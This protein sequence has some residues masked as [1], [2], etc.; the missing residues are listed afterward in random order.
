MS[1]SRLLEQLEDLFGFRYEYF[2]PLIGLLASLAFSDE[3][4]FVA[5]FW[6]NRSILFPRPMTRQPD[7]SGVRVKV[8]RA[9]E[10]ID[11]LEPLVQGFLQSK[12]Y[13]VFPYNEP[14]T[15]DLVYKAKV[16]AQPPLWWSAVIG[17]AIHNLRSSLDLLICELVR[18][19][20]K[21]VKPNTGFPVFKNAVAFTN[22][23]K[24]GP[25]GQIKG[26]PK[27]AVD[28]IK[29]AKPYKGGDEAF[30]RLH[31]LDITDKHKLLVPVGAA[32]RSVILDFARAFDNIPD[33]PPKFVLPRDFSMPIGLRPADRQFP[34]KDGVELFR[35]PAQVRNDPMAQ[36]HNNPQFTFEVAFGEGEVVKGEPLL[37]TLP[38]LAQFVEEFIELFPPLFNQK[39]IP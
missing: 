12:P 21:E 24:S 20:G 14:D 31:Q 34:L 39:S 11:N 6:H 33:L 15:G 22:A 17:D 38:Q 19:E 35:V 18:A 32:Y 23:F 37:P 28:L 9:K 10:H 5:L 30:W 7:F 29:K 2:Q 1:R 4:A 26:A 27:V 16:L 3:R 25:P 8:E 36:V 13:E